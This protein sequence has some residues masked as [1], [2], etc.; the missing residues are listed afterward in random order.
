MNHHLYEDI[1]PKIRK[2][3]K[4][5]AAPEGAAAAD[6]WLYVPQLFLVALGFINVAVQGVLGNTEKVTNPLTGLGD[7]E[8]AA[9]IQ[10]A[11]GLDLVFLV[12][13]CHRL[14]HQ[15]GGLLDQFFQ[16]IVDIVG[17]GLRLSRMKM[18][19]DFRILPSSVRVR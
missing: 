15:L 5:A 6:I 16:Q 7:Q 17:D 18:V 11:D 10:E 13:Q 14:A 9:V 3:N 8:S 12:H 1:L 19:L 2:S 4:K